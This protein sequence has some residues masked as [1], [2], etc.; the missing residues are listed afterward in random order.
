VRAAVG[1]LPRG[2][3]I[4]RLPIL[5]Q[6]ESFGALQVATRGAGRPLTHDDRVLLEE[7]ARRLG[8]LFHSFALSA[9]LQAVRE[10]LVL[11]REEERRRIRNDL[12]DGL[13]PT[14]AALQLHLGALKPL[15]ESDPALA[16]ER[17]DGLR[18]ELRG[19]TA[20]IRQMVYALRP[21]MIDELGLVGAVR[22]LRLGGALAFEVIA[23]DPMPRLPAAVE[24]AAFRIASEAVLNVV[25]HAQARRCTVTFQVEGPMLTLAVEDDGRG[26]HGAAAPGVGTHSMRERA[27]ELGGT[28]EIGAGAGA[29][30]GTRLC[31]RLP[32][33]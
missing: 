18:E 20:S 4:V 6:G 27:A 9:S 5:H 30:G 22:A 26:L 7:V 12:H 23:P 16:A 29:L 15:I 25:R 13:A 31:A 33:K 8:I 19:A 3:A 21:P 14:L 24:V 28:L 1:H 32:L 17:L 10:R 2:A 11:A